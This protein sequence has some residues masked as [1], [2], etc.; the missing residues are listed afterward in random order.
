M[1]I[2]N[3]RIT[4]TFLGVEDHGIFTFS[5][6]VEIAGG[7]CCSIGNYCLSYT[8]NGKAH[9]EAKNSEAICRILKVVGVDSWEKLKG[10][11]IRVEENGWGSGIHTIG[12]L[13]KDEWFNLK[14]FFSGYYI[15][16]TEQKS[17]EV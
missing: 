7:S 5:I 11:Y 10:Q 2:V 4:D 6:G 9:Y 8:E 14:E 17:Y 13:M 15:A 3:A 1:S 16:P 12:N